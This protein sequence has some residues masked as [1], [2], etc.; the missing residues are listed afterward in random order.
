MSLNRNYPYGLFDGLFRGWWIAAI[1]SLIGFL[2]FGRGL[3]DVAGGLM[4]AGLRDVAGDFETRNGFVFVHGFDSGLLPVLLALPG[5]WLVDRYGPRRVAL[6]GLPAVVVGY[7]VLAGASPVNW[8]MS[9]SAA[10]LTL[11]ATVGYSWVPSATLNHWF[12]RRKATAMAIPMVAFSLWHWANGPALEALVASVGWRLSTVA[13]GV[14]ALAVVMPLAW[15]IRDNPEDRGLHPDG[16]PPQ[17][18]VI[19]PKY[20]WREA[21]HSRAF[22]FLAIGDAC[23]S[24]TVIPLLV[25]SSQFEFES[26]WALNSWDLTNVVRTAAILAGAFLADQ[27][28]IRYVLA[29]SG[30][31]MVAAAALLVTGSPVG[32]YVFELVLAVALGGTSAVRL[33]AR[34]VY[35]GRGS[36]AAIAA[37]GVFVI[38]PFQPLV[39]FGLLSMSE[40]TGGPLVPWSIGLVGCLVGAW[41]YLKAGPP[42]TAPWR[43]QSEEG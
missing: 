32:V 31:V 27:I 19:L 40:V 4:T 14:I 3:P 38:A 33:A 24:S 30:A 21:V 7:L 1:L 34:G 2:V 39:T 17:P 8:T 10:L 23:I 43:S 28:P 13:V 16:T 9:L 41:S 12:Q 37:T 36:Y 6:C 29:G 5:A 11:G 22:W 15:Q 25:L 42:R 35:F 18:G 20:T 26:D